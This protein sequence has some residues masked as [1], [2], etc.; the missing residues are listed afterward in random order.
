[1]TGQVL[2]PGCPTRGRGLGH[3]SALM[4]PLQPRTN[5]GSLTTVGTARVALIHCHWYHPGSVLGVSH[6]GSQTSLIYLLRMLVP[7]WR[8]DLLCHRPH[9]I[10]E[11][12]LLILLAGQ[13]C[14]W[15]LSSL[16]AAF[17]SLF[18]GCEYSLKPF[19]F[20]DGI[21]RGTGTP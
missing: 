4:G 11:S 12:I 14:P 20:P 15:S 5:S 17:Q 6:S 16:W 10:P 7:G 1:M 2:H 19:W 13:R 8:G 18:F 9:W 21:N 3:F